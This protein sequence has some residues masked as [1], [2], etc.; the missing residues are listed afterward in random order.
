[1]LTP[2]L[3]FA[4][5]N[6]VDLRVSDT[7]SLGSSPFVRIEG[8]ANETTR[9]GQTEAVLALGTDKSF[10]VGW[11]SKRQ[12][13][14]MTAAMSRAFDAL[15]QP[16]GLERLLIDDPEHA[17]QAPSLVVDSTGTVNA[18]FESLLKG[19]RERGVFVGA[20]QSTER[21]VGVSSQVVTA[22]GQNG[23]W[24]AVYLAEVGL[25]SN[26]VFARVFDKYGAPVSPEV[27]I[28]DFTSGN[29]AFPTVATGPDGFAVAWQRTSAD[30]EPQGIFGR[31]LSWSGTAE[32]T[33]TRL[34]GAGCIE[35]TLSS[36]GE[37]F[38]LGWAQFGAKEFRAYAAQLDAGLNRLGD[39]VPVQGQSGD[40]VAV[41]VA[42]REDG[43][44]TVLWTLRTGDG[45]DVYMQHFDVQG[46]PTAPA[47]RATVA[48]EGEQW[49]TQGS[50]KTRAAWS[51]G[52]LTLVWNGAAGLGDGNGVH[53]TR[54]TPATELGQETVAHLS[55]L[56][57]KTLAATKPIE[58]A[59]T[60]GLRLDRVEIKD[61]GP[62]E[63][64]VSNYLRVENG[65]GVEIPRFNNG[66]NAYS[67]TSFTPPDL[68]LAVG[69]DHIVVT[70]NDGIGFY[71]KTGTQT[72]S[73]NMRQTNGFWGNLAA[74]DNF[75]YDPECF[76]DTITGRF[77]VM[78]TQ[79]AGS[80]TDSAALV[81]VSDDGDPNG[82]W[83]KYRFLTTGQA[84]NFF[85][86][87]NFGVDENVLYVTGD[88]FGLGAN[89]PVFCIEKA[90]MLSGGNP[91]IIRS[92]TLPT[93]T[94]SAG[95]P[96]V[97]TAQNAWY[98][99]EHKEG[100]SNTAIDLV[101][102]RNPL[103]AP[104]FNRF[105]L[106]V[107]TYTAPEDP[108]QNGSTSR[109]EAFDAR[110]WSVKY[111]NGMIWASHHINNTRVRA[112]WYQIDPRGW[113][114]S[115]NNPIVVQSGEV[116]LGGT[117]RTFF[118]AVAADDQ[119]NMAVAYARSSP[120]EFYSGA[121]SYRNVA[122]AA[123]TTKGH[124][125]D[126]SSASAYT[127]GRW[128]DYSG[129]DADN[130]YPGLFWGFTEW[131]Q[132]G[133]WR[134]WVQPFYVTNELWAKTL[135]T[136]FGRRIGGA[137]ESLINDDGTEL[138]HQT[139]IRT[140]PTDPHIR[141]ELRTFTGRRNQVGGSVQLVYRVDAAGYRIRTEMFNQV[142]G[143]WDQLDERN[144]SLSKTTLDLAVAN[145]TNYVRAA[146]GQVAYRVSIVQGSGPVGSPAVRLF[147]DRWAWI[148]N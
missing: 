121:H 135:T 46:R 58:S 102:L 101:A 142:T 130:K 104:T 70:V 48:Q 90:P 111:R 83:H 112:R 87:P 72:F 147:A 61:A 136:S 60:I 116:D 42:G 125:I 144:A 43:Q 37:G 55:Q 100:G 50:S 91:A 26:R 133:S 3:C 69:D 28:S 74:P 77:W 126:V 124:T 68:N 122:D 11:E 94:Q 106:T 82:V 7:V 24:V 2:M 114:V 27:R 85:D 19:G 14:G 98:M 134:A 84:G 10:V 131:H 117:L 105:T 139:F 93:S 49:L 33:T 113:P 89:Y 15:G 23:Q 107:P 57:T 21:P 73:A 109:V 31:R 5:F 110:M 29:D 54:W 51:G 145:P 47:T 8:R 25:G 34:A 63:P 12:N 41:Q 96:Q 32:S 118:P 52:T 45:T 79:G 127:A 129:C 56:T 75:I 44:L 13:R 9:S 67:Q 22:K 66:F 39:I 16:K 38:A 65:W 53:F 62:H 148:E 140:Q 95:I 71:T 128:G 59:K 143:V 123:G 115:G 35:P 120:T 76:Y 146:D 36:R 103:T 64:P 92:T 88:G 108:P 99:V 6:G 78:A 18:A 141:Y 20:T 86:S 1:M 97:Q 119:G 132:S 30:K 40:Q 81:A 137:V 17:V 80:G 138:V 4:S